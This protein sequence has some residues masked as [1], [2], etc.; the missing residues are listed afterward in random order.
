MSNYTT[1][2]AALKATTV[3]TRLLDAKKIDT[4]RLF[5]K[6]TEFDPSF[7]VGVKVWN[8]EWKD[9]EINN[10]AWSPQGAFIENES[11]YVP[12]KLFI[13]GHDIMCKTSFENNY[14]HFYVAEEDDDL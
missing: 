5:I 12:H 13:N 11:D 14:W 4:E 9:G 2:T 1:Q 10:G 8:G 3:D 6:G 7:S